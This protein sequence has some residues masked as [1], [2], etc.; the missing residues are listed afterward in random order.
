MKKIR[1]GND[2]RIEWTVELPEG[3]NSLDELRLA[4]EVRPS[5]ML[6]DLHECVPQRRKELHTMVLHG[7]AEPCAPPR[8]TSIRQRPVLLPHYIED[9]KVVA[10]WPAERQFATGDYDILMYANK[11][12]AG[13]GVVDQ[14]RFVR[15]VAHS[16]QTEDCD[17]DCVQAVIELQPVTL[18]LSG[19]SA[20]EIAVL[21]GFEGTEAEWL[22]SLKEPAETA[23]SEAETAEEARAAAEQARQEAETSRETAESARATAE[24]ERAAAETARQTQES[25]R[26][27]AEDARATAESARAAQETARET[28][29]SKRAE[30]EQSRAEAETARQD[31]EQARQ[32]A[33]T[34]REQDSAEAV[35]NAEAAAEDAQETASHPSYCGT[36]YYWYVW[37]KATKT[38]DKTDLLMKPDAF[39]ISVTYDSLEALE[40]DTT[41]YAD[42][43]FA[44]VNTNDVENPDN[45]KLYFRNNGAWSFVVDMSGAI[46]FTGK[47]P[48]ISIGSVR[49]G[50]NLGDAGAALSADGT[51][52]DGNPKYLLN[53][54]IPRLTYDDLTDDEIAELQKPATDMIAQLNTT[55]EAVKQAE[56]ERVSAETARASA[57][58]AR[59]QAETA[60]QTAEASRQTAETSRQATESARETAEASRAA[61]E[62]ERAS[63]EA[64]RQTAE[65]S[66][67]DA[68]AA[69]AS[70]ET[71]RQTAEESRDTAEQERQTAEA[72]RQAAETSR[73]EAETVRAVSESERVTAET[74]RAEAESARAAAETA[75]AKAEESRAAAET[76]REQA[77]AE[78]VTNAETAAANAD[79]AT[80]KANAATDK[81]NTAADSANAAAKTANDT[82]ADIAAHQPKIVDGCW[83]VWDA[84]SKQYVKTETN[85]AGRSPYIN[86][87]TL[88]WMVYDDTAGAYKDSGVSVS[89][90][91]ELTKAKVE[92]ALTGDVT[93]HSHSTQIAE[94]LTPYA[95]TTDVN[96][97]LALKA[98]KSDTY[99]KSEVDGKVSAKQ[100]KLVSGTSLK[101]VNGQTLLGSGDITT[102]LTPY[103][104]KTDL[105]TK[106]SQLTNDDNTVKDASYVH[107]DNNYTSADK[108]KLEGIEA[109]AQANVIEKV[110]VDGAALTP[111]DKAVN[112]DLSGKQDKLT[113]GENI[114]IDGGAISAKDTTYA[115][116]TDSAAGLMSASDKAK[117]N[118]IAE[119]A[120]KVT[121]D[122][123]LSSASTNPVQNKAIQSALS[124][125][126]DAVSGKGL[127][128]NDYTAADK[129]KLAAIEAGAQANTVTGVK[130]EAEASY[131]TGDISL[132]PA[133]I[134]AAAESHTHSYA[135]LTDT[136]SIGDGTVTIKQGGAV[137]GSFTLNQ[138]GAATIELS[139]GVTAEATD[140]TAG[141]MSAADKQ[142][143]DLL[144]T[145][146]YIHFSVGT[147]TSSDTTYTDNVNNKGTYTFKAG[148][149]W[150]KY[151]FSQ[152]ESDWGM[153][154][155]LANDGTTATWQQIDGQDS[156]TDGDHLFMRQPYR[157]DSAPTTS[158]EPKTYTFGDLTFT[159]A[160]QIGYTMTSG[161]CTC[162]IY[163]SSDNSGNHI[164]RE[165]GSTPSDAKITIQQNGE[166]VGSFTLNQSGDSVIDIGA[167][168]VE[169][170]LAVVLC[171]LASPELDSSEYPTLSSIVNSSTAMNAVA[172]SS[173]AMAAVI[174][175]STAMEAVAASSTAM[176]AVAASST[177]MAAV[178]ASSTAMAAVAA[179]STAMAAV[180][181]SSTAMAAVAASSTAMEAVIASS[182]ALNAVVNSSTAMEAVAASSTA[183]AAVA[184]SGAAMY[185]ICK[186][187]DKT[188][189]AEVCKAIMDNGL[190]ATAY[191]TVKSATEYFTQRTASTTYTALPTS[192]TTYGKEQDE[193]FFG[194]LSNSGDRS[195]ACT[196]ISHDVTMYSEAVPSGTLQETVT[197]SNVN[198]VAPSPIKAQVVHAYYAYITWDIYL[199][200]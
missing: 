87:D 109:G 80:E 9:G 188:S 46:G 162:Y 161:A 68:E 33:E 59:E 91:Y 154:L 151:I 24:T 52:D 141:L 54:T 21:H 182:T 178:A 89:S 62:D 25:S 40:A 94:A 12:D 166:T 73:S 98:D 34:K 198:L 112:I 53:F 159:P 135:D 194:C 83:A 129:A 11:G 185:A 134:G 142:L 121:V 86:T 117:L 116:A 8:N 113:A 167:G 148:D 176:A 147:P 3:I 120:T 13:Q 75:R 76:E 17:C 5:G 38:Y 45:A 144:G 169:S 32:E 22:A 143:V 43:L 29:E 72:S 131:R 180:A 119:G 88:T 111:T 49:L 160:V 103:A 191:K 193:L 149:L 122:S 30:A 164:W 108:S 127:S 102:D 114:T 126:V 85:A 165:L 81:A 172:A 63:A 152:Y 168:G 186:M 37:N 190:T 177:A 150:V 42:G 67:A 130:G 2:I 199:A 187:T 69:R 136:P 132:T 145:H 20:Y 39:K 200:N 26:A 189:E 96:S 35:K 170:A 179:S 48:Q 95:K 97:S 51:D 140:T 124:G 15:L 153:W 41:A 163:C 174:A 181:A 61:A 139:D 58:T 1:I 65:A 175:S 118:A 31:S 196:V 92:A 84:A 101:T 56:A 107:T 44:M 6:M 173:T 104:K 7:G 79:A 146:S 184:A 125:K 93:S 115:E 14:C 197:E 23:A 99:T 60:R 105:P 138:E 18:S 155:C 19:L 128:T 171:G 71:A 74:S 4:V 157:L 158:T 64:S 47:T 90:Q 183:M 50:S 55:D 66:R 70:A 133:D 57:E 123:A 10:I 106:T 78:A 77:S 16:S 156:Q 28:A 100:D 192:Y 195:Y 36:D 137:K 110:S 27:E 82:S